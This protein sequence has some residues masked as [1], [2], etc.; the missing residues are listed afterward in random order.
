MLSNKIIGSH[1][2]RAMLDRGD[3]K[4][5]CAVADSSDDEAMNG[6][7]INDF[8]DFVISYSDSGF[9]CASGV[10]WAFAVPI[11]VVTVTEYMDDPTVSPVKIVEMPAVEE[12]L[13]DCGCANW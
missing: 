12:S 11:K 10:E 13:C 3:K 1:L 5:W 4:I 2:T 8:T 7:A 6:L 9:F